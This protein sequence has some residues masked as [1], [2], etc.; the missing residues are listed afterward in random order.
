VFWVTL[1][2]LT[3]G[4]IWDLRQREIPD[5]IPGALLA[6][7]ICFTALGWTDRT[8][9]SLLAGGAVGT[10]IGMLLFWRGGFG[11]A[12]VKLLAALGT[13]VGIR[14]L[15]PLLFYVALA[16]GGLAVVALCRGQRDLAYGPAITLGFVMFSGIRGWQ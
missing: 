5:A 4:T 3:I 12:D 15:F 14:A 11:G 9:T 10:A 8:W 2:L 7:A 1:V 16:G 6:T 13:I